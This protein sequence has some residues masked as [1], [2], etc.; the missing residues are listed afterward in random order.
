VSP[1]DGVWLRK[2]SRRDGLIVITANSFIDGVE[3]RR[4]S[5]PNHGCGS[6][7]R[8]RLAVISISAATSQVLVGT[9]VRPRTDLAEDA[10][11]ELG[12]TG[13]TAAD[14]YRETNVSYVAVT[15]KIEMPHLRAWPSSI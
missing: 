14:A 8:Y 4:F 1:D 2:P 11:I 3:R 12:E 6:S 9:G 13:A 7:R 5:G 15:N 10:G